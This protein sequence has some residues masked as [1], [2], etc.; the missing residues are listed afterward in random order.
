MEQIKKYYASIAQL[1]ERL[2]G[3]KEQLETSDDFQAEM[4]QIDEWLQSEDISFE[5]FDDDIARYLIE[6]IR[7]T[8]DLKLVINI[9]GGGSITEKLCENDSEN[10]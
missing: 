1:R 9:K 6:S 5:E 3:V 7:V 4:S 8:D 2:S 10:S